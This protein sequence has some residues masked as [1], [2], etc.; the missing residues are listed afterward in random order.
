M[1]NKYTLE[2]CKEYAKIKE[3]ECLSNV[4]V[5]SNSKITWKCS[6][7]YIWEAPFCDLKRKNSWCGK[8]ARIKNARTKINTI[9]DAV[10]L[11][12]LQNGLCVSTEYVNAVAKLIWQCEI[13][14]IWETSY[15]VIQKGSW[16][17][18][19]ANINN[20]KSKKEKPISKKNINI[21]TCK[22]LASQKNGE[23]LSTECN[24]WLDIIKWKCHND[25]VWETKLKNIL[26][27]TWC[28]YC[29]KITIEDCIKLAK[30]KN[31]ICLSET[32]TN[33][34]KLKWQCEYDH[35]WEARIDRIKKGS[36]CPECVK[37]RITI[38]DCNE[39][40]LKNNGKC[41]SNECNNENDKLF[42]QCEKNHKWCAS[43]ANISRDRWCPYCVD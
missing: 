35:I 28:P 31:G 3:G 24:Y 17:P 30:N 40:A 1:K 42:W 26:E 41:L 12:K 5:N 36:W 23:C 21:D 8:C 29:N 13:G 10:E 33:R 22:N 4:Y 2:H 7:G 25:H 19:C 34:I 38:N 32:Y 14:H 9:H 27:G 43:Y 20:S 39:V 37:N 18:Q 6:C 16:C 15:T 11:A